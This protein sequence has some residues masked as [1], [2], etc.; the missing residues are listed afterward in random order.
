MA[1]HIALTLWG[2]PLQPLP[3]SITSLCSALS[4]VYK[5]ETGEENQNSEIKARREK[6]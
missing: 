4:H 1:G 6:E 5:G 3:F 2:N